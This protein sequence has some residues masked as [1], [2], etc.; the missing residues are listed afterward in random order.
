[1]SSTGG[2]LAQQW[3]NIVTGNTFQYSGGLI[4]GGNGEEFNPGTGMLLGTFDVGTSNCCSGIEVLP[5]SAINRAFALGQTPFFNAFGITSY[6]LSQFTPLAVADLSELSSGFNSA[7]ASNFIQWGTNGLAFIST[8]GCCA[9][10][11]T[12]VVLIQSPS[13][14]L[15]ASKTPV[16]APVSHDSIPAAAAHGSG[17]FLLT[18]RGSGFVP[19]SVVT[20]NGKPFSASYV[21]GNAMKVYVP[22]A[23][24]AS[25]GTAAIMVKNPAPGGGRSNP[26]TFTIR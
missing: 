18:V 12:Q 3:N 20:W 24:I 2:T 4:F 10:T 15:T 5:N 6:N 23:A 26:L 17:N 16:P 7:S 9:T 8:N 22:R 11:T 14:L 21:N 25:S 13:L 1:V 19:G